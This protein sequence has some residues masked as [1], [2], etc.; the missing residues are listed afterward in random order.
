MQ[1]SFLVPRFI[2]I[3]RSSKPRSLQISQP[4][5]GSNY[6]ASFLKV[7]STALK[8]NDNPFDLQ[9]KNSNL[10]QQWPHRRSNFIGIGLESGKDEHP[11]A[12]NRR[13][14]KKSITLIFGEF[15]EYLDLK[16]DEVKS[17]WKRMEE[18]EKWI[19]VKGFVAE[20]GANFHPLSAKSAKEMVEEY[21]QKESSS[22]NSPSQL[23][24]GL[25]RM[26]G[27]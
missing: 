23:F 14:M 27:L 21:L 1:S 26:M 10:M 12:A 13:A 20:W 17:K 18:E 8:A 15:C 6:S 7:F 4:R 9:T 11:F 3:Y 24:L 25:R 22:A 19:L 16:E 2:A 5:N